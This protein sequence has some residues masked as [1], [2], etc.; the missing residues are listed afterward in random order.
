MTLDDDDVA[1][2]LCFVQNL[3]RKKVEKFRSTFLYI[4]SLIKRGTL[5][6]IIKHI[7]KMFSI[8]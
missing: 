5:Y 6:L 3:L 7:T 2:I 4:M 8:N 1:Q